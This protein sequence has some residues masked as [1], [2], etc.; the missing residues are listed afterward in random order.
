VI[1]GEVLQLV[2][3]V[4]SPDLPGIPAHDRGC[5]GSRFHS[6]RP[7]IIHRTQVP[8]RPGEDVYLCGTC[9]DNA[10][11]LAVLEQSA[12]VPWAV[13][14]CFGNGIRALVPATTEHPHA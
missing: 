13:R 9:R 4:S 2:Q 8:G 6:P 5:Q 7:M 10:L 12:H 3:D 11:L 14:R 1:P